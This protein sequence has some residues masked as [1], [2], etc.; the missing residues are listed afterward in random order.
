MK[1]YG[2]FLAIAMLASTAVFA[3]EGILKLPKY[4]FGFGLKGGVNIRR[5]RRLRE[6]V[7]R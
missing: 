2:I 6:F 7:P 1:K 3:Q 4:K 5:V